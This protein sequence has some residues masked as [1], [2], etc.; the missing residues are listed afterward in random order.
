MLLVINRC[1]LRLF[2]LNKMEFAK[3][4]TG[5]WSLFEAQL[6]AISPNWT[7]LRLRQTQ[8]GRIGLIGG[9]DELHPDG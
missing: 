6:I 5:C 8:S 4:K 9:S 2:N 1:L 7:F 3:V